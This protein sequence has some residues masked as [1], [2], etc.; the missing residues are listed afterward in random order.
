MAKASRKKRK[1]PGKKKP[2]AAAKPASGGG[3]LK[4]KAADIL[5]SRNTALFRMLSETAEIVRAASFTEVQVHLQKEL[6]ARLDD[7]KK[8]LISELV[9][10]KKT[11]LEAKKK[12]T[13]L[14]KER[15]QINTENRN[16]E[17]KVN[18]LVRETDRMG[19]KREKL[20]KEGVTLEK[21]AK[22]LREDVERL[23]AIRKEYLGRISKYRGMREDLIR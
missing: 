9:A 21:R 10:L 13:S 22:N 19:E 23:Q 12:V 16:L 17:K 14:T 2:K 5:E 18:T 11:N 4:A 15:N 8:T 20:K 1:A 3:G 6:S 7:E